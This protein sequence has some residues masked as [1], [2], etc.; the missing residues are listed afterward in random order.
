MAEINQL[1]TLSAL[2]NVSHP[3]LYSKIALDVSKY[4]V[5]VLGVVSVGCGISC[6]CL[7]DL[8]YWVFTHKLKER[9]MLFIGAVT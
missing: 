9:K 8:T 7:T 3:A 5:L 4:S 2:L 6:Q 1:K